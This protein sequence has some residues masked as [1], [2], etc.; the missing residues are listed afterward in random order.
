LIALLELEVRWPDK[1]SQYWQNYRL[2]TVTIFAGLIA[3]VIAWA[4]Q[5]TW[6]AVYDAT[7]WIVAFSAIEMDIFQILQR[8]SV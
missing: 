2:A 6:L 5:S 7:L 8:N 4:W 1:V 3:V